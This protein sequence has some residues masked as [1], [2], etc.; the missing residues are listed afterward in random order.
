MPSLSPLSSLG[1]THERMICLFIVCEIMFTIGESRAISHTNDREQ[2]AQQVAAIPRRWN[3]FPLK[4]L[5]RT[6]TNIHRKA[7]QIEEDNRE[8]E[9]TS[10]CTAK[11]TDVNTATTNMYRGSDK[12]LQLHCK[13]IRWREG[14]PTADV[15]KTVVK[16]RQR[17]KLTVKIIFFDAAIGSKSY[18][19][20]TKHAKNIFPT[21]SGQPISLYTMPSNNGFDSKPYFT[22]NS[23]EHW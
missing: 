12:I 2:Q 8:A 13:R 6:P 19:I 15:S 20:S 1:V 10:L 17:L 4:L 14:T 9:R 7:D 18:M 22:K 21:D 3:D 5:W 11:V 16:I 23:L